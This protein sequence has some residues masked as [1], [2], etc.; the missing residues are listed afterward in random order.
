MP[1]YDYKCECGEEFD[2]LVKMSER[3][4]PVE[5]PECGDEVCRVE[6]LYGDHTIKYN[7]DGFHRTDYTNKDTQ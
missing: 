4:D 1:I 2:K 5:C 7:T 6:T 3:D